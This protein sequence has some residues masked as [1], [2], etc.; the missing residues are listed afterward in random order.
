MKKLTKEEIRALCQSILLCDTN[1]E[2]AFN[3]IVLS[4]NEI[5]DAYEKIKNKNTQLTE[6]VNWLYEQLR[7]SP[8]DDKDLH[9]P[10]AG[11]R[12]GG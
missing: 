3:I 2:V 12:G 10:T 9:G 5:W 6:E 8:K 4:F 1:C 11:L 7:E